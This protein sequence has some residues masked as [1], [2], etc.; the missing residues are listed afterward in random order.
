MKISMIAA[1]ASL[2]T[3]FM[4]P[5]AAKAADACYI[6]MGGRHVNLTGICQ[7]GRAEGSSIYDAT[8]H[9]IP[10]GA[11]N[12]V[13]YGVECS[14]SWRENQWQEQESL[15]GKIGNVGSAAAHN[16]TVTLRAE[17]IDESGAVIQT[18]VREILIPEVPAQMV[19]NFEAEFSFIPDHHVVENIEWN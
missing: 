11:A 15:A 3:A 4:A 14:W 7:G 17:E 10:V 12:L 18:E 5:H 8:I 9:H 16:I 1:C 19:A 2:V 6:N 13:V